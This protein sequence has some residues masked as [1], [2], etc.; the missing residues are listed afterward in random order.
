ME[1]LC[2]ATG[3]TEESESMLGKVVGGESFSAESEDESD[4]QEP[5]ALLVIHATMHM[6]FLPQFTCE[7]FEQNNE[8]DFDAE[9]H[10]EKLNSSVVIKPSASK[11][12]SKLKP[13]SILRSNQKT[14]QKAA[15]GD[16][17]DLEKKLEE[18]MI[19]NEEETNAFMQKEAGLRKTNYVEEG[20][21]LL[22]RPTSIVW[23]G[24]IGVKPNK[25]RLIVIS[26]YNFVSKFL[27]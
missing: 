24:G 1:D 6:L 21:L 5:L 16:L 23:A 17:K 22:P 7:F 15:T 4:D 2:W 25:V 10:G 27:L 18:A 9:S 14:S 11:T 26:K 12:M 13:T 19:L 20:I 3:E 8:A